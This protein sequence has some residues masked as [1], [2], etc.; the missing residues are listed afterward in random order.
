MVFASAA[1]AVHAVDEQFSKTEH[2][3]FSKQQFCSLF[4]GETML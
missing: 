2:A 1:N 4:S 3:F